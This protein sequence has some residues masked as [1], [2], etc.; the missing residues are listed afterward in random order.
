MII[1]NKQIG[2]LILLLALAALGYQQYQQRQQLRILAG[3]ARINISSISNLNTAVVNQQAV[4]NY[5][6]KLQ[7][8]TNNVSLIATNKP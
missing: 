3:A 6:V 8:G 7:Q 5:L 2:I 4:L 1:T